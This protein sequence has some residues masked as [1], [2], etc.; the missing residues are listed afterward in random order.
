MALTIGLT[1]MMTVPINT[2]HIPHEWL[3]VVQWRE[4]NKICVLL[5]IK[6]M[7]LT[8]VLTIVVTVPT[9]T[10]HI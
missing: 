4:A 7:V 9:S 10:S 1:V 8:I 2:S 3:I 6:K 5:A